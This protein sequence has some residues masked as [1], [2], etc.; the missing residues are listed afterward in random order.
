MT[1]IEIELAVLVAV[2]IVATVV[3]WRASC[4]LVGR[5]YERQ[6]AM[7]KHSK[8]ATREAMLAKNEALRAV[9]TVAALGEDARL[10]HRRVDAFF[11]HPEARRML[12][13]AD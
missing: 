5:L 6:V 7:D 12:E 9:E 13:A 8:A 2:V 11:K 10:T 4:E 1:L 3:L